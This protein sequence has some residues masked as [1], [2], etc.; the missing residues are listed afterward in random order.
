M[1]LKAD[2]IKINHLNNVGKYTVPY[3]PMDPSW[4]TFMSSINGMS[5]GRFM[6]LHQ[7]WTVDL[8]DFFEADERCVTWPLTVAV[9]GFPWVFG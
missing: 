8:P 4:V 2:T 9:A 6:I 1:Y 3:P 7:E 5:F